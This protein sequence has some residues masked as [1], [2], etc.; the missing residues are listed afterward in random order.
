MQIHENK[1]SSR[2]GFTV[3]ELAISLGLFAVVLGLGAT[4]GGSAQDAYSQTSSAA[5][6]ESQVKATLDRVVSEL[7]HGSLATMIP[8]LDPGA[9]DADVLAIQPVTDIVAGAAV[10]GSFMTIGFRDDPNDVIDGL[11]NDGDGLIDEGHLAFIRDIGTANAT[12]VILCK[13]VARFLEGETAGAG[14]ENG[15]GVTDETGLLFQR[16]GDLL[17]ISLTLQG[18]QGNGGIDTRTSSVSVMMRN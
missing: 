18:V 14:D 16:D 7:E 9:A 5:Q 8:P 15:N 4:V 1:K 3:L 13:N 12:N 11:D 2:A 6:L 10:L 17:T